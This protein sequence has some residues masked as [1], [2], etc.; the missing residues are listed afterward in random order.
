MEILIK[1][2]RSG[3][4]PTFLLHEGK[5]LVEKFRAFTISGQVVQL[6]RRRSGVDE[7]GGGVGK[8][9]GGR[10]RG[11]GEG[12]K[13]DVRRW[14]LAHMYNQHR[15]SVTACSVLTQLLQLLENAA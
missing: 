1:S 14:K 11:R 12:G 13:E 4:L 10:E 7:K 5:Q 8:G 15:R 6:R 3:A 9:R 2:V